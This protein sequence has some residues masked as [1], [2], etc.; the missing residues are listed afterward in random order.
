[1]NNLTLKRLFKSIKWTIDD[2]IVRVAYSIIEDEEQKWHIAVAKNLKEILN[3]NIK[4]K[5]YQENNKNSLN[6]LSLNI[7]VNQ[8]SNTPLIT[9]IERE[10]LRHYMILDN[11]VESKFVRIEQEY[12]SRDRLS[13]NWL[14]PKQ[15]ILF[16]WFPWC[17]KS[18]WAERLAWDIWLPFLKVNFE[19][20][21]SSYL[22]ESLTNLRKIFD[23]VKSYPCVL[24]LDE[25]DII[26]K[27]RDYKQDVWEMNRI[28]NITLNL[29]EDFNSP[30]IIIATTNLK[31]SIDSAMF[32]RFDEVV[33]IKKPKVE[34]IT[35]ILQTTLIS[36]KLEKNINFWKYAKQLL[37]LSASEIV[38]IAQNAWKSYI[39]H[40]DKKITS[41]HIENSIN[42]YLNN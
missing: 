39:I 19:A 31:D 7:P 9:K 1:M 34:E 38:K 25:F 6:L 40:N 41:K 28:V 33:E 8:R 29:L 2:D 20:I 23:E 36:M 37:W 27:S 12:V 13:L 42:E 24:L 18:M 32:R 5:E 35:K 11:E 30:W 3:K 14:K 4:I 16:Y 17:W 26:A 21:I 22:W 10:D 15:K